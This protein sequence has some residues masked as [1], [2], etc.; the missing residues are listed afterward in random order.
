MKDLYMSQAAASAAAAVASY[1]NTPAS[2]NSAAAYAAGQRAAAAAT[3]GVIN[4][5]GG[6]PLDEELKQQMAALRRV[7]NFGPPDQGPQSITAA[8]QSGL[9]D[10]KDVVVPRLEPKVGGSRVGASA[11]DA[12]FELCAAGVCS[13][14]AKAL[15]GGWGE[16]WI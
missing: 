11:M 14:G 8:Q 1:S 12:Q 2:A 10:Q 9:A 3:A 15:G 13:C 6:P 7:R 4:L 16:G 5:N